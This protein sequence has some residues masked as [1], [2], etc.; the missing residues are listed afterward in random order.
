MQE[1]TAIILA[2]GQ[3][4]RFDNRDK[5]WIEW[6]DKPLIQH[7]IDK[8][9]PQA[10]AIIINCN[11]N[12]EAYQALG[13]PVCTDTVSGFQGPLAGVEAG[14]KKVTTPLA[15]VCPVDAPILPDDL[16]ARLKNALIEEDADIVFASDGKRSHYLPALLKTALL[17]SLQEYLEGN[18]RR[19]RRWYFQHNAIEIDFSDRPEAF[20]NVNTAETL[21]RLDQ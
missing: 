20:T 5:G 6:R 12:I 11:R 8:V 14:L 4:S 7:L 2:G 9:Q 19:V 1:V 13:F 16:V 15:L 17:P 3:G 10:Q 18:E 21:A